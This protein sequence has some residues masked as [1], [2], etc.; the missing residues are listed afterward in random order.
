MGQ[1]MF[2]FFLLYLLSW[3]SVSPANISNQ[4]FPTLRSDHTFARYWPLLSIVGIVG[5]SLNSY[6]LY[7]FYSKRA[8][9]VSSVNLMIGQDETVYDMHNYFTIAYKYFY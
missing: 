8:E 4:H 5:T 2:T 9:M 6:V 7:S 1:N 3:H